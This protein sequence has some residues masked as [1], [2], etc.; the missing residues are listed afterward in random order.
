MTTAAPPIEQAWVPAAPVPGDRVAA[1]WGAFLCLLSVVAWG[2]SVVVPF[3]VV[4]AGV[5]AVASL[6]AVAGLRF[7]QIGLLG[8]G[9]LCALDGLIGPLFL[10]GGLLR[11]STLNYWLV[12]VAILFAPLLLRERGLP[13]IFLWLFTVWVLIG[14]LFSPD[15]MAGLAQMSGLLVV[16]GLLAYFRRGSRGLEGWYWMAVTIALTAALCSA[17]FLTRYPQVGRINPNI[18]SDVPLAG[19]HAACLGLAVAPSRRRRV[20]LGLLTVVNLAWVFLSGSRGALLI[21]LVSI[22]AM[23]AMGESRKRAA[24]FV[25]AGALLIAAVGSQFP[26]LARQSIERITL[27]WDDS[28]SVK[29]RTSARSEIARGGWELF[30]R[31]PVLGVGTGGFIRERAALGRVGDAYY[32][33]GQRRS[34]HSAWVKVLAENGAPGALLLAGYVASFAVVGLRRR[35]RRLRLLAVATSVTLLLGLLATEFQSKELWLFTAGCAVLLTT[36]A[37]RARPV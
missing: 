19:I 20:I 32:R 33:P 14:L 2:A 37:A 27:L 36:P 22:A 21:G 13:T 1:R 10:L 35:E 9:L 23:V 31:H 12:G 29:V 15:R 17:S 4:L 11:W 3:T 18:W 5:A 26:H 6:A 7:P 28:K 34:A 24:A 16:V 25:L 30:R 8:I